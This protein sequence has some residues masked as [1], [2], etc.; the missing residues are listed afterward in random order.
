VTGHGDSVGQQPV[1]IISVVLSNNA[2][3]LDA[4][5]QA[6]RCTAVISFSTDGLPDMSSLV[7]SRTR[8]DQ[9]DLTKQMLQQCSMFPWQLGF[10]NASV[11][12]KQ[13]PKLSRIWRSNE[14]Y[15]VVGQ[16]EYNDVIKDFWSSEGNRLFQH[17]G[18]IVGSCGKKMQQLTLLGRTWSSLLPMCQA[19][20]Y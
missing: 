12:M 9:A 20:H 19:V 2:L 16:D 5:Q 10:Q 18:Q 17:S 1:V 4:I 8:P 11:L 15:R 14:L 3:L 6:R 7:M 13:L